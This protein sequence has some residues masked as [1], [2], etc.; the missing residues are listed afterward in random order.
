[1]MLAAAAP[2]GYGLPGGTASAVRHRCL[3]GTIFS[4]NISIACRPAAAGALDG[5]GAPLPSPGMVAVATAIGEP[6]G[7]GDVPGAEEVAVGPA[8][9]DDGP[10]PGADAGALAEAVGE[11]DGDA[12]AVG[13]A[14]GD[15]DA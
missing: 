6:V 14:D 9:A 13:E 2:P 3:A 7:T 11:A 1:M 10:V 12:D 15:G 4:R 5:E 8:D